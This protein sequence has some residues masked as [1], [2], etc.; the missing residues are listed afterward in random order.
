M[1]R[2]GT[3]TKA[4]GSLSFRDSIVDRAEDVE[5]EEGSWQIVMLVKPRE[6]SILP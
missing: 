6:R 1:Y 2:K 5:K 4:W 3:R